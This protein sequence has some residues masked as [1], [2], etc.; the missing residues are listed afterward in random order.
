[1]VKY[2][3]KCMN[4]MLFTCQ[5][6][7]YYWSFLVSRN[8]LKTKTKLGWVFRKIHW[9]KKAQGSQNSF[10]FFSQKVKSRL[11]CVFLFIVHRIFPIAMCLWTHLWIIICRFIQTPE[12]SKL[13]EISYSAAMFI[14]HAWRRYRV[15]VVHIIIW[16]PQ[17]HFYAWVTFYIAHLGS[18]ISSRCSIWPSSLF[19]S[20]FILS[21]PDLFAD[22]SC[23]EVS[24][25]SWSSLADQVFRSD[26]LWSLFDLMELCLGW[27]WS[28]YGRSLS[29]TCKG[30]EGMR[31][32]YQLS[33]HNYK[34][35]LSHKFFFCRWY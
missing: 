32:Y 1:M 22:K 5:L 11:C 34:T 28:W 35:M 30:Q 31:I 13:E 21:F 2:W 15:R 29:R 16:L 3:I 17:I 6:L 4:S 14:E 33:H 12:L 24:L 25:S 27:F 18:W 7:R 19:L 26:L 20:E 9:W 8:W 10:L 23:F